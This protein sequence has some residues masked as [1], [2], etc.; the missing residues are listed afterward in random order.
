[1]RSARKIIFPVLLDNLN[2]VGSQPARRGVQLKLQ[3]PPNLLVVPDGKVT[4]GGAFSD[5]LGHRKVLRHHF[6]RY[7]VAGTKPFPGPGG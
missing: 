3:L 2:F 1:M 6:V 5:I 4:V 7:R